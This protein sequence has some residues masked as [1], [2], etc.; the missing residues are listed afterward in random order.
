MDTCESGGE[1]RLATSL[2]PGV[3]GLRVAAPLQVGGLAHAPPHHLDH[4]WPAPLT[5]T[6]FSGCIRNLRINGEVR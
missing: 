6:S 5:H 4:G 3:G 2:P 1:C